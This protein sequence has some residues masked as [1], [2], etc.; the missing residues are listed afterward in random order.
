MNNDDLLDFF[1]GLALQGLIAA[2][3]ESS[4]QAMAK[5]SYDLAEAMVRERGERH[6]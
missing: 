5:V 1:A 2:H 4:P 3:H 6:E